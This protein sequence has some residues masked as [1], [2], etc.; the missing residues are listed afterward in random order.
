MLLLAYFAGF[1]WALTLGAAFAA[2]F[3]ATF[4]AFGTV[5]VEANAPDGAANIAATVTAA[6]NPSPR[7]TFRW[8]EY[9]LVHSSVIKSYLS[10][11]AQ[12]ACSV[13]A[14]NIFSEDEVNENRLTK[15]ADFIEPPR[16]LAAGYGPETRCQQRRP[17]AVWR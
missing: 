7:F 3:G 16:L 14:R 10:R 13:D 6:A 12:G 17:R 5:F 1:A 8:S 11:K 4:F 15:S 2:A 9:S